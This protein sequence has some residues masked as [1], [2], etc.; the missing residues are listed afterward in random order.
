MSAQGRS[1][2]IVTVALY[3]AQI[4]SFVIFGDERGRVFHRPAYVPTEIA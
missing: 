3:V 4:W 2:C 1:D